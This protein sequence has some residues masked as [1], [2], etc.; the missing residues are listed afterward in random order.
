MKPARFA[1]FR[2]QN[3]AEAVEMIAA[4]GDD[5]RFL[6]GGQSLVPM[7]NFRIVRPSALVDLSSCADLVYARLDGEKVLDLAREAST[8]RYRELYGF[9][10]GD[11]RRVLKVR[12]G[13]G[14]DIYPGDG[15]A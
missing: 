7:M 4:A 9:T 13:R 2:P 11:P 6:A 5:A 14:V 1:Y 10:H 8:L 12:I 15:S 3:A